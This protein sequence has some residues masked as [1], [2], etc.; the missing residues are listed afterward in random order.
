M[1]YQKAVKWIPTC[2]HQEDREGFLIQILQCGYTNM[3]KNVQALL[4][5]EERYLYV[6]FPET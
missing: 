2:R 4:F 5:C 6:D 3:T 1:A